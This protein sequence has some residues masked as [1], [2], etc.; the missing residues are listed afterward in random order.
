MTDWRSMYVR[1]SRHETGRHVVDLKGAVKR[2]SWL[3]TPRAT[4]LNANGDRLV[5]IEY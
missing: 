1:A 4:S 5:T 2:L 3:Q